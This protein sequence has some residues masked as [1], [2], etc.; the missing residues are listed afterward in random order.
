MFEFTLIPICAMVIL[1]GLIYGM[2]GFGYV[3]VS[4]ALLPF[5]ISVKVAVPMLAA[6]AFVLTVWM[7]Y[8]LRRHLRKRIVLPILVGLPL[9][10][11]LGVYLLHVLSEENIRRL[12]GSVVLLYVLWSIVKV[13]RTTPVL[14]RDAW[15]LM[16]GFLSG[17]IGGAILAAGPIIVIYLTLR[18]LRKEEFKATFLVWALLQMGLL[19]PFYT[20]TGMLTSKVFLWGAI[21]LPFSGVGILI[22]VRLFERVQEQVFYR[23]VIVLLA[24][25]GVRL[26]LS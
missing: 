26:L 2:F 8:G 25:S 16:A 19:V 10:L 6:Q 21:S 15:G 22:G 23:L 1:S 24:L 3:L 7:L 14:R 17:V 4:V 20:M 18:G 9:G 11:P 13:S 5:F 12:L